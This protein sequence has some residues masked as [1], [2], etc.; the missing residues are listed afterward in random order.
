MRSMNAATEHGPW[1]PVPKPFVAALL[2][3]AWTLSFASHA[4]AADP[5]GVDTAMPTAPAAGGADQAVVARYW[6]I[7]RPR[8]FVGG[9]I[10]VG[11]A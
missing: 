3:A 1:R 4:V 9:T 5:F 6:E 7:G 11:I 2:A 8:S 10:D